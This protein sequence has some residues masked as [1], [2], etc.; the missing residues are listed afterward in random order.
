MLS[1]RPFLPKS[2]RNELILRSF[3]FPIPAAEHLPRIASQ[4]S[5]DVQFPQ[6]EAQRA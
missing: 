4:S 5:S 2:G 6:R 1:T 3:R